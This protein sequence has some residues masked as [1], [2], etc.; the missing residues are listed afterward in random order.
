MT[1]LCGEENSSFRWHS[2]VLSLRAGRTKK[3]MLIGAYSQLQE[4]TIQW[5]MQ[6]VTSVA[7]PQPGPGGPQ[8]GWACTLRPGHAAPPFLGGG[9]LHSLLLSRA[10]AEQADQEPQQLQPPAALAPAQII[11]GGKVSTQ[12]AARRRP[13]GSA[14]S[15]RAMPW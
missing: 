10:P 11:P 6:V 12:A 14:T 7:W 4:V 13:E 15:P 9:L 1:E 2:R 5:R 8:Q 3:S